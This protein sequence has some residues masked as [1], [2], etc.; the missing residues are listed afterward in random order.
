VYSFF[1][2]KDQ[3]SLQYMHRKVKVFSRI[4]LCM[5]GIVAVSGVI[6]GDVYLESWND[7]LLSEYGQILLWKIS[8]FSFIILIAAFHRF[9]WLPRLKK[10]DSDEE[11]SKQLEYLVC[12][13]RLELVLVVVVLVIAGMLSTASP[14][15]DIHGDHY[16]YYH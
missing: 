6:L 3:E 16:Y 2:R 14:P 8:L 13:L 12:G 9:I 4:A 15:A 1:I 5:V 11:K 7:L 10:A